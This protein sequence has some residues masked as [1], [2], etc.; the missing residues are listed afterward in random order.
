MNT[1]TNLKDS[2]SCSTCVSLPSHIQKLIEVIDSKF[3]EISLQ[4]ENICNRLSNVEESIN[5]QHSIINELERELSIVADK[6]NKVSSK[7]SDSFSSHT[8]TYKLHKSTQ[9]NENYRYSSPLMSPRSSNSHP[10][11]ASVVSHFPRSTVPADCAHSTVHWRSAPSIR[12]TIPLPTPIVLSLLPHHPLTDIPPSEI[13]RPV[14]LM[15]LLC[16]H[17]IP[18]IIIVLLP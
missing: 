15:P 18:A 3:K 1:I 12:P 16:M 8:G 13:P 2:F 9:T 4:F 6:L 10:I 7:S 11:S 17:L 14:L 5:D